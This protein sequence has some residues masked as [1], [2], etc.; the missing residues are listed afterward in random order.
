MRNAAKPT[1]IV[2]V[3]LTRRFY[4]D[5]QGQRV[6]FWNIERTALPDA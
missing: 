3:F 5:D 6:A 4:V 2:N 1:Q